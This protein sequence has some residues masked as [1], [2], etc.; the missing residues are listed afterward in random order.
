[1]NCNCLSIKKEPGNDS[2]NNKWLKIMSQSFSISMLNS[3]IKIYYYHKSVSPEWPFYI[4]INQSPVLSQQSIWQNHW[5]LEDSSFLSTLHKSSWNLNTFFA[6][7]TA[8]GTNSGGLSR[9]SSI[10]QIGVTHLQC[11]CKMFSRHLTVNGIV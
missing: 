6:K 5:L 7:V 4:Q 10:T 8:V 11:S 9:R 3:V 1:M 2:I